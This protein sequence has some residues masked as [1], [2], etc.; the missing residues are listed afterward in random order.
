MRGITAAALCALSIVPT[1]QPA[2]AS[3]HGFVPIAVR[4]NPIEQPRLAEAAARYGAL[5][6]RGALVLSS[7]DSRFGSW[8][9]LDFD[10]DGETLYA[11]GDKGS[12][13]TARLVEQDGRIVGIED[14]M[15]APILDYNATPVGGG[16]ASDAEG[17]RIV[18]RNGVSTALVTFEQIGEVRTFAAAPDF[19]GA[20]PQRFIL[21]IF[22]YGV[23]ANEG[24]E[25]IAVAPADSPLAGAIVLI[26]ERSLN[27]ERNHRAFILNGPRDG[28]FAIRR[29]DEFDITDA[30]FLPNGDLLIL[31]RRFRLTEGFAMRVR[32]IAAA[33]IRVGATVSGTVLIQ[34]DVRDRIDNMEGMAVTAGDDG[35]ALL[36]L[37]SDD[38]HNFLQHTILVR[39]VVLPP[40]PPPLPRLRPQT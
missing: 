15:L 20:T 23:R 11:V 12:W 9:G 26:A 6:P 8:S 31:E 33:A 32:R 2:L 19:A 28:P 1:T 16:R 22:V 36:T 37:I 7:S 4:A 38:N 40:P 13:F 3:E 21:P 25:S 24:L 35:E 27:L 10:R 18:Q 34:A 17:L 29:T 5:E 14:A 30:A 39:F